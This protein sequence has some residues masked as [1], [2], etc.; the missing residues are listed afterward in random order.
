[1]GIL[2]LLQI[3]FQMTMARGAALIAR[4]YIHSY[5]Y[6]DSELFYIAEKLHYNG[7]FNPKA[8]FQKQITREQD[9]TSTVF[10]SPLSDGSAAIL[11]STVHKS[12]YKVRGLGSGISSFSIV[13]SPL[14][15]EASY[16]AFNNTYREANVSPQDIQVVSYTMPLQFLK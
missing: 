11:L 9:E 15:F 7:S 5:R 13:N 12:D 1:M 3:Q 8:H 10:S 6:K 2:S 14:S 4:R 16:R